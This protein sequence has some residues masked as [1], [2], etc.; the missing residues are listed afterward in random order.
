MERKNIISMSHYS[1]TVYRSS[2][3]VQKEPKLLA[4]QFKIIHDITNCAVNLCKWNVIDSERCEYC[5]VQN[6]M[7]HSFV[8]CPATRQGIKDVFE[9]IDPYNKKSI[10]EITTL[11]FIFGV[12][13]SA[14]N[15]IILILKKYIIHIR[16]FKQAF[17]PNV[18]VKQIL[19]RVRIDEKT[20]RI[21]TFLSKWQDF[22]IVMQLSR[23]LYPID[24]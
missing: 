17:I 24:G 16:S 3:N 5:N 18:V 21:E 4:T 6:S 22:N 8:E 20:L 10:E 7:I 14:L 11:D 1:I 9:I 12:Q 23:A 15:L 2:K 19:Q 13:N